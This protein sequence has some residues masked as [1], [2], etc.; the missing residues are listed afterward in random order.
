MSRHQA[1]WISGTDCSLAEVH[2]DGCLLVERLVQAP[3]V[4][5]VEVAGEAPARLARRGVIVQVDLLVAARPERVSEQYVRLVADPAPARVSGMYFVSGKAELKGSSPPSLDPAVQERI[6]VAAKAW[7]ALFL[8]S[9][10]SKSTA[11]QGISAARARQPGWAR[12]H[13]RPP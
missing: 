6:E 4:V 12:R 8:G 9:R 7:A 11:S 2:L 1:G 10:L 13:R 3:M 5:E